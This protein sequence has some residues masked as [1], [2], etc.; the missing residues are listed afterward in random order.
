MQAYQVLLEKVVDQLAD[1]RLEYKRLDRGIRSVDGL[2]SPSVEEATSRVELATAQ[3]ET[4]KISE[5]LEAQV[6]ETRRRLLRF[7]SC[8][9]QWESLRYSVMRTA[10]VVRSHRDGVFL[11]CK[12]CL[13]FK[14][15]VVAF[16]V[17][18]GQVC[19]IW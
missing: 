15:L 9:F 14:L 6:R 12:P 5:D 19:L 7:N 10:E 17:V 2:D 4:V 16:I 3:S 8:W 11:R 18:M 13:R 1:V